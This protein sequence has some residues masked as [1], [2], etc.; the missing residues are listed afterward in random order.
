MAFL[1][2][3]GAVEECN[4]GSHQEASQVV[5]RAPPVHHRPLLHQLKHLQHTTPSVM[6]RGGTFS[7]NCSRKTR[8]A[9]DKTSFDTSCKPLLVVTTPMTT[10]IKHFTFVSY[11]TTMACP[12]LSAFRCHCHTVK[13][14][15]LGPHT[16]MYSN[17][18]AC[19]ARTTT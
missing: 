6:P 5:G 18:A 14:F 2:V 7:T 19:F 12:T 17:P 1:Q 16:L 9:L 13:P 10:M 15:V 8:P 3:H 4:E 11:S